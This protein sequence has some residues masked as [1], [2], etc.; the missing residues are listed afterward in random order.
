MAECVVEV[1]HPPSTRAA[2]RCELTGLV[3][4]DRHRSQYDERDDLGPYSWVP[5]DPQPFAA[6]DAR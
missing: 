5:V 1:G 4:C 6:E 3:V 2:W